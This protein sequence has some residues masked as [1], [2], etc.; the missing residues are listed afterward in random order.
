MSDKRIYLGTEF[1]LQLR[2]IDRDMS[3][4]CEAKGLQSPHQPSQSALKTSLAKSD[5]PTLDL[6]VTP[7]HSSLDLYLAEI[8]PPLRPQN[9]QINLVE[10]GEVETR[11]NLLISKAMASSLYHLQQP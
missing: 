10:I 8:P 7:S 11:G 5:P 2:V 1:H 3:S 6:L 4:I 9:Q